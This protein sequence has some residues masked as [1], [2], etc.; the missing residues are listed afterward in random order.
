L[1]LAPDSAVVLGASRYSKAVA[2]FPSIVD[3]QLQPHWEQRMSREEA[4]S[5][6]MNHFIAYVRGAAG[7]SRSDSGSVVKTDDDADDIADGAVT[8]ATTRPS[9]GSVGVGARTAGKHIDWYCGTCSEKFALNA[10]VGEPDL[11]DGILPCCNLLEIDCSTGTVRLHRTSSI[12]HSDAPRLQL[13]VS[14]CRS[15]SAR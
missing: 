15:A 4:L 14:C 13:H 8:L 12:Q 1:L 6:R 5:T 11:V 2:F 10:T 9:G 3:T 7:M